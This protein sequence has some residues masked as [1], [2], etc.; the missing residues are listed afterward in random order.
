V[1]YGRRLRHVNV[2]CVIIISCVDGKEGKMRGN[3]GWVRGPKV[4]QLTLSMGPARAK[5]HSYV[6]RANIPSKKVFLY[7]KHS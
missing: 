4:W 5:V 2:V 1:P 7:T 3:G 6:L